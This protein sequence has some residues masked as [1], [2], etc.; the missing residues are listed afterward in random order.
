MRS[1]LLAM[2]ALLIALVFGNSAFARGNGVCNM[3]PQ[4]QKASA[5]NLDQLAAI[6][7]FQPKAARSEFLLASKPI[8]PVRANSIKV[9][10]GAL[11]ALNG[12]PAR[13]EVTKETT[14]R[15]AVK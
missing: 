13:P 5:Q 12:T 3:A 1:V 11:L 9:D 15:L 14:Q 8:K 10:R 6:K 2:F 7:A 4:V